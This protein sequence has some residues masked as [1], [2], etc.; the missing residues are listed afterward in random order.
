MKALPIGLVIG[1][2][3]IL[4]SVFSPVGPRGLVMPFPSYQ[5]ILMFRAAYYFIFAFLYLFILP[6]AEV[7][8]YFVFQATIWKEKGLAK[9]IVPIAYGLMSFAVF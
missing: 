5:V 7:M 1:G 4:F 9:L 6:V 8:F 3:L 2:L